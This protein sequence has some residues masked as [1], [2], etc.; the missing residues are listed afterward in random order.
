M[1]Q[2]K[3]GLVVLDYLS[4]VV[5]GDRYRGRKVDEIAEISAECKRIV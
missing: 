5:P 3:L 4:L 1:K 2:P